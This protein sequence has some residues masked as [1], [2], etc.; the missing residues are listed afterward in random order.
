MRKFKNQ[1]NSLEIIR[2]IK[3]KYIILK[4]DDAEK[5]K[6]ILKNNY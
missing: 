6:K 3:K 1:L 2:H 5:N 4:M